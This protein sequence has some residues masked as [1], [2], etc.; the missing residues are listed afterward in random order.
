M[1]EVVDHG[2]VRELRLA[3]PPVNALD[4]PLLTALRAAIAGAPAAGREAIVLSGAPGRFSGGL[5]V[6]VLLTLDRA[7]MEGAWTTVFGV[8]RDIAASPISIVAAL[9]QH[10]AAGG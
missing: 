2:A 3:R 7:G 6:P 9:T 10:S 1:I 8:M 5:D 4:P